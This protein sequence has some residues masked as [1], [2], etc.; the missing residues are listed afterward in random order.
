MTSP[1]IIRS[2]VR[3]R[4]PL[5]WVRCRPVPQKV[6]T[7]SQKTDHEKCERRRNKPSA[8]S[9]SDAHISM[10]SRVNKKT[11]RYPQRAKKNI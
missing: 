6:N 4:V 8:I 10:L 3:L 5:I 11:D 2:E 7:R 1:G 9:Q